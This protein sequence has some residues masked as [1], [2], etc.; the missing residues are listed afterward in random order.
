MKVTKGQRFQYK[1]KSPVRTG[2]P[3]VEVVSVDGDEVVLRAKEGNEFT[4][5]VENLAQHYRLVK[6]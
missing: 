6:G 4:E 3:I 5:P 1:N 2:G